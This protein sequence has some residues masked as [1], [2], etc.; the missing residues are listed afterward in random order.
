[1]ETLK[2]LRKSELYENRRMM[3]GRLS[4]AVPRRESVNFTLCTPKHRDTTTTATK[5]LQPLPLF[6]QESHSRHSDAGSSPF[7][8]TPKTR[9]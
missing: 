8:N 2:S 7:S 3:G 9:R 6:L 4:I 1:M 5:L